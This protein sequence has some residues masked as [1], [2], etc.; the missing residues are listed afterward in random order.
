MLEPILQEQIIQLIQKSGAIVNKFWQQ[1]IAI[2][3]KEDRTPVTEV[4][5]ALQ[6]F[7]FEKLTQLTPEIPILS[8]ENI[9]DFNLAEDCKNFWLLDPLDGTQKFINNN[10]QCAVMLTLIVKQNE[11][12]KPIFTVIHAP[13]LGKTYFAELNKGAFLITKDK[14]KQLKIS[15]NHGDKFIITA[16]RANKEKI[17]DLYDG[18][19]QAEF[20]EFGSCGLKAGLIAENIANCYFCITKTGIWD[21]AGAELLVSEAGGDLVDLEGKKLIYDPRIRMIN[22]P[23]I[24]LTDKDCNWQKL[25]KLP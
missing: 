23:F 12:F 17:L 6:E 22:P 1:N 19:L 8:E 15:E 11:E 5:L 4:D 14:T 18:D 9:K 25:F 16:S 24:A 7:I 21:T 10:P 20:I 2:T 3:I 13:I